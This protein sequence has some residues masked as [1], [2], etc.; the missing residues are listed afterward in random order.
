LDEILVTVSPTLSKPRSLQLEWSLQA[1]AKKQEVLASFDWDLSSEARA[2]LSG[3]IR[4]AQTAEQLGVTEDTHGKQSRYWG[5]FLDYLCSIELDDNPFL[6]GLDEWNQG[7]IVGA[8][9]AAYRTLR[10]RPTHYAN[11]MNLWQLHAQ[12]PSVLWI[13]PSGLTGVASLLDAS[14]REALTPRIL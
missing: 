11:A 5:W 2:T 1:T 12:P 3:D 8:Y 10:F 13:R 9:V 7:R 6:D 14:R 4:T